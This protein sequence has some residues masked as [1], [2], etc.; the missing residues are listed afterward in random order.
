MSFEFYTLRNGVRVVLVPMSGVES[1]AVGVYVKTGSRYETPKNNGISHFLE[2]MVFKGTKKFPTHKDTSYLEG[3]GAIQ[4]AWTDVGA[5]AYWCKLPADRWREGLEMVK[6]LALYPLI[7]EADLEIERGVI[8]EEINRR[9]DRP[10]E[11]AGELLMKTMYGQNP[12]AMTVLGLPEVIISVSKDNFKEYQTQQ[13]TAGRLVVAVAGSGAS[14]A[15]IKD[16]IEKWFRELP[17]AV[18]REFEPIGEKW[19]KPRFKI[20]PKKLSGQAHVEIGVPGFNVRDEQRFAAAML[21]AYLG[22]GMSSRLFIELREKRGL[23]Y[24]VHASHETLEDV[25]VWETYAGVAL[26]KLPAAVEAILAEMAR[27]KEVKL[28][29]AEIAATREKLRGPLL[30]SM[31]NPV[32][33]M[34]WYAKQALDRPDQILSHGDVINRLMQIDSNKVQQA[35]GELFATE[36]LNVAVVGPVDKKAVEG[37]AKLLRV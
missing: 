25:G 14:R 19:V 37:L 15:V 5:T 29:A 35:A 9:N 28:T 36:R 3:L 2:H 8:L 21:T 18:G 4:N 26:E 20:R 10:E 33:Q 34:N 11:L 17:G 22:Q 12:L 31:E 24:A 27:L 6:E 30:F 23:C 13:Y 7:P 32:N 16:Q 1:V